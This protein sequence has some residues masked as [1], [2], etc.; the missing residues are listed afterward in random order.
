MTESAATSSTSLVRGVDLNLVNLTVLNAALA[1]AGIKVTAKMKVDERVSLLA[2]HD[3]EKIGPDPTLGG[4]CD[5]CG[6]VSLIAR[7]SCPFCGTG[8]DQ[9]AAD[10]PVAKPAPRS[11]KEA[12]AKAPK[13]EKPAK[14]PKVK[15]EKPA[16]A[17]P[18][19]KPEKPS[20][21]LA[22][23]PA[24]QITATQVKEL[25]QTVRRLKGLISDTMSSHWKLGRELTEVMKTGIYKYR[26]DSGKL[27]AHANFA[28]FCSTEL[29]LSSQ[30]A[31]SLMSVA[32]AFTED[33]VRKI[34]VTK[35]KFLARV[36]EDLRGELLEKAADLPTRA[37]EAEVQ[38]VAPG[39][40]REPIAR[41]DSKARPHT[42]ARNTTENKAKP[43]R[44]VAPNEATAVIVPE[45]VEL[46]MFARAMSAETEQPIRAKT[47]AADPFC[48]YEL[49]NG[50]QMHI[51]WVEEDDGLMTVLEFKRAAE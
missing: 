12:A 46:P 40:T 14:A 15:P 25:D 16:K 18:E 51:K 20:K 24:T 50:M 21:A 8:E 32:E 5:K 26:L 11:K 44:A 39:A 3:A 9:P 41:D 49:Q 10:S 1:E 33:Q 22:K 23:A 45:R 30:Y 27:P 17:E 29:S 4:A 47:L 36:P 43:T 31:R 37:F 35:L 6:G 7:P 34:G 2:D 42:R 13:A 38:N 19:A 48:V 28:A